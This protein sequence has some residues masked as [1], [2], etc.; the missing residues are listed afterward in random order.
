MD[1]LENI[2]Y[3]INNSREVYRSIIVPLYQLKKEELIL[4]LKKLETSL[5]KLAQ[6]TIS[7]N[8]KTLIQYSIEIN[9]SK[10]QLFHENFLILANNIKKQIFLEENKAEVKNQIL[11][12]KEAISHPQIYYDIEEKLKNEINI[13]IDFLESAKLQI[14]N[15]YIDISKEK[16]T[17]EEL[18]KIIEAKNHVIKEQHKKINDYSWLEAK[19][20]AKDSKISGLEEALLKKVKVTEERQILLKIHISKIESE[21]NEIYRHIKNLNHDI[22]SLDNFNL[23]KEQISL[24]L[25]RELKDELLATRY[26]LSKKL[27]KE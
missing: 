25:I 1:I 2:D 27:N 9:T 6:D 15:K 10:M 20:K 7:I 23:E 18:L 11:S 19:E 5:E 22:K 3:L 12:I 17:K 21:I 26:A 4:T 16:K 13:Y 14:K 8:R 24:E